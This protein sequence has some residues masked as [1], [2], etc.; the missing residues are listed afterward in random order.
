VCDWSGKQGVACTWITS[1]LG[2]RK[3]PRG[4]EGLEGIIGVDWE[5]ISIFFEASIN[6]RP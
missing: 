3:R 4:I 2:W 1:G 5:Q 6:R